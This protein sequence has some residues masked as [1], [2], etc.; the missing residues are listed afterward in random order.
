VATLAP[1]ILFRRVGPSGLCGRQNHPLGSYFQTRPMARALESA[2][3]FVFIKPSATE[4][5]GFAV[6]HGKPQIGFVFQTP[7]ASWPRY[8]NRRLGLFL[9]D[10]NAQVNLLG[11]SF[12]KKRFLFAPCICGLRNWHGSLHSACYLSLAETRALA[13]AT[14][15]GKR[16]QTTASTRRAL[17][18]PPHPLNDYPTQPQ[19]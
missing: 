1:P 11:I 7:M 14:V 8:S 4:R 12:R 15:D 16:Q 5:L 2:I 6:Q 18:G 10:A 13:L 19:S 17:S 9:Q 3:G